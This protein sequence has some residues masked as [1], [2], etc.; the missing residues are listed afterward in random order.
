MVDITDIKGDVNVGDEVVLFGKQGEG[1]IKVEE[2][3]QSIGTI[4]YEVV[5]I[6]GK[7]YQGCILKTVKVHNVLKLFNLIY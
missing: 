5:S 3:A 4:N 2:L 1:E 6:I 7:E